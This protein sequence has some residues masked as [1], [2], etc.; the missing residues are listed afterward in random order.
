MPN[1]VTIIFAI[2]VAPSKSLEAPKQ[3]RKRRLKHRWRS[4]AEPTCAALTSH[5]AQ[6]SPGGFTCGDVLV[7]K[8]ELLCYAAAHADVH[9]G[10]QLPSGLAPA[11]VLRE[12]GH[13]HPKHQRKHQ[14]WK[15]KPELRRPMR[16][17]DAHVAESR[18]SGHDG[19]LIDG[20]CLFGVIGHDGMAGLVVRCDGLVL[21]VDLHTFPLGTW[22]E[23]HAWSPACRWLTRSEVSRAACALTH[24]DL[25]FSK[26]Q[27]LHGDH[28]LPVHGRLQGSLVDQVL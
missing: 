1:L 22:R 25:V 3:E 9:L 10:Q 28:L 26:L 5:A 17:R 18:S 15:Q 7:S 8:D 20:H 19:G 12:H 16:P 24:Q 2:L 4:P 11:V 14:S 23:S 21:L 6:G 13:L 27:I